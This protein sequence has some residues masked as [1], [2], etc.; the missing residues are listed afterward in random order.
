M[1]CSFFED[2][3]GDARV[4]LTTVG[5]QVCL[6]GWKSGLEIGMKK[7][8]VG[9]KRGHNT[10]NASRTETAGKRVERPAM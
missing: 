9:H 2:V 3:L 6:G 8:W 4:S 10:H 7:R 5:A 1:D